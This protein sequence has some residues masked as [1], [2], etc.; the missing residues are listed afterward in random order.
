MLRRVVEY[1]RCVQ[2]GGVTWNQP[3]IVWTCL[4]TQVFNL[5][6]HSFASCAL[7]VISKVSIS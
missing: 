7:T 2:S 1:E 5:Q 4:A 3:Y 6:L